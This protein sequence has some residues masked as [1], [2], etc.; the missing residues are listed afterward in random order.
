M[1]MTMNVIHYKTKK[2]VNLKDSFKP[3]NQ[4]NLGQLSVAKYRKKLANTVNFFFFAPKSNFDCFFSPKAGGNKF[5]YE[6]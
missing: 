6:N 1:V 3:Y 5:M 2:P 4:R